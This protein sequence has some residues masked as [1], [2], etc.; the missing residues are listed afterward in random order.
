MKAV[1]LSLLIFTGGWQTID[2]QGLFTFRLP[3]E[4]EKRNPTNAEDLRAEYHKEK[5]K[6]IVLWGQTESVAYNDRQQSWMHDYHE[7][8]TRIRGLRANIRTYSQRENA[9]VS[10]RA[11]LNLGNWDK[12]E[13]QLYMRIETDDAG[14][15]PVAEEIFKSI[16][17]PL[18]SPER[19]HDDRYRM[20]R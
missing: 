4:F 14:M 7:S 11:E 16:E 15:L 17:L 6:L 2:F 9:K 3:A 12:G 13:V 20:L 8:T 1:A 10:Y 19:Q 18:P 5:T